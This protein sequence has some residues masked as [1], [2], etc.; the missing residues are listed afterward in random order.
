[1]LHGVDEAAEFIAR[2]KYRSR[3]DEDG[4]IVYIKNT[5]SFES[6]TAAVKEVSIDRTY[7]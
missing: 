5:K 2:G 4:D 1:M 3:V 6:S 7:G